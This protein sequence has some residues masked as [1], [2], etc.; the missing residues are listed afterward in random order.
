MTSSAQTD[1]PEPV[2]ARPQ[3][4]AGRV[5]ALLGAFEAGGGSLTLS[6]ISR[7]AGLSLTTTHRLV[8]EVLEWGGLEVDG[9]GR[10]RLSTKFLRLAS[11]S[12]RGLQLRE[13]A[14]PHLMDLHRQIGGSTVHL[15]VQEGHQVMYLE[16]L[17][18]YP[19]YTGESRIGG[20]LPMHV[21]AAGLVLLAHASEDFITDYLSRPLK[22]Y[23]PKTIV[24]P[25]EL[26]DTLAQ[27]RA[28][29]FCV[30]PQSIALDAGGIAAPITGE[31]MAVK[32]AVNAVWFIEHQDPQRLTSL[33]RATANRI[34][35]ALAGP[36][37]PLDR[38]TI[39]FNRRQAGL[40]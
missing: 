26:L 9:A 5:L 3:T 6:E 40:G 20:G 2:A 14:L 1:A 28:Q 24:D 21:T 38:R 12:T 10:Y 11:N 18:S 37:S 4:A 31:D 29:R 25:D 30:H 27:V 16:A 39:D 13:A 15:A 34:S 33:V 32:A 36:R 7:Q 22:R 8:R 17:R 23:T 35:R 19:N